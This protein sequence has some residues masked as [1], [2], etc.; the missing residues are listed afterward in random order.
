VNTTVSQI[1]VPQ[2]GLQKKVSTI[3][4]SVAKHLVVIVQGT[5]VVC[6]ATSFLFNA[7]LGYLLQMIDIIQIALH[8]PLLAVMV[9]SNVLSFFAIV[10]SIINYDLLAEFDWFNNILKYFSRLTI[11]K[12][13]LAESMLGINNQ[14]LKLGYDTR[15]PFV[16]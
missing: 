10:F 7:A 1:E 15:N 6:F 12:K 16:N 11:E 4:E 5:T 9:P 13:P 14:T 8:I 3:I 2:Q